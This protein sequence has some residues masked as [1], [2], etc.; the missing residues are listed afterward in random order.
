MAETANSA[1]RHSRPVTGDIAP[2]DQA[3]HPELAPQAAS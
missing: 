3:P 2:A 1:E